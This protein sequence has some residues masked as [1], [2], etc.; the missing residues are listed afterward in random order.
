MI[1]GRTT[2]FVV[3]GFQTRIQ[4][5]KMERSVFTTK[6]YVLIKKCMTFFPFLYGKLSLLRTLIFEGQNFGMI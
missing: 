2:Q 5:K 3:E 6:L 4:W 1:H